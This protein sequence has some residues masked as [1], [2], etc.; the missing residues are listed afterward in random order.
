[1]E[2]N[3]Q[4]SITAEAFA[5]LGKEKQIQEYSDIVFK[6]TGL[7]IDFISAEGETL[8]ISHMVNFNP[9]C[10]MLRSCENGK[11]ACLQCDVFNALRAADEKKAVCYSCYAGLHEIVV[12]VFDEKENYIGCMT[13]GQFHLSGT[14]LF[15]QRKILA[16]AEQYGLDGNELYNAYKMSNS[17]APVQVEGIIAYLGIIG[18][19]LTSIREHLIFMDKINVPDKISMVKKYIDENFDSQ[20]TIEQVAKKFNISPSNLAHKFTETVNVSFQRYVNF[21]RLMRAKEMLHGTTLSVSEIAYACGFGSVSQF[22]R[23]FKAS[24]GCSPSCYR[25][26]NNSL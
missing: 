5:M 12:P 15:T 23:T 17:L 10:K 3:R 2:N 26:Q 18:R 8:R 7:V 13:S 21:R 22:N 4:N 6:L 9:Y 1:M 24:A 20:L 16:L 19:Q 11:K 14:P 25:E